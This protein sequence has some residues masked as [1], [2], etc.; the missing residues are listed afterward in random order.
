MKIVSLSI[1]IFLFAPLIANNPQEKTEA[2]QKFNRQAIET[3][4]DESDQDLLSEDPLLFPLNQDFFAR[5]AF[6]KKLPPLEKKQ[7]IVWAFRTAKPS[8]FL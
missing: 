5:K 1:L 7:E 8:P 6:Q 2:P 3:R 4:E